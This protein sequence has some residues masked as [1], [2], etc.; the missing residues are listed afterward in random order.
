MSISSINE[1]LSSLRAVSYLRVSTE[2]QAQVGGEP[3]GLSI[4]AKREVCKRRGI[5]MGALVVAEFVERGWSGRSLERPE[6]KRMLEYVQ[7]S[8]VDFVI[9]H[10]IDR[11]AR[12]RADDAVVTNQVA[13]TGA[14]LVSTSEAIN[15]TPLGR[16]RHGTMAPIAEFYSHNLATE[17]MKGTR[18]KAIQ[19]GTPDVRR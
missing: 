4:P 18:Q 7:A 2:R 19:G 1:S 10:K 6:L 13:A 5:E 3:E 14:H 9:V 17:V 11:L 8:P 16:L 12:N 15:S